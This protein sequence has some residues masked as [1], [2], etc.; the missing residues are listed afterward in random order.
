MFNYS[1]KEESSLPHMKKQKL[2]MKNY[3]FEYNNENSKRLVNNMQYNNNDNYY[4]FSKTKNHFNGFTKKNSECDTKIDSD[5]NSDILRQSNTDEDSL[6]GQDQLFCEEELDDQV[7]NCTIKEKP[8]KVIDNTKYKTEMCKNWVSKGFCN[9]GKKCKFAHGDNELEKKTVNSKYKMKLCRSFHQEGVCMYGIRCCFIHQGK[10]FDEVFSRF[11]YQMILNINNNLNEEGNLYDYQGQYIHEKLEDEIKEN[12]TVGN[13]SSENCDLTTPD[14]MKKNSLNSTL[15]KL[16][17]C[18]FSYEEGGYA[19]GLGFQEFHIQ[20]L[21]TDRG[22][23]KSQFSTKRLGVF[24]RLH[25][26]GL[27]KEQ[28]EVYPCNEN[29]SDYEEEFFNDEFN[30]VY[31][32]QYDY[33][34]NQYIQMYQQDGGMEMPYF[35]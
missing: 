34:V 32:Q 7:L 14:F 10:N 21:L 30:V 28:R 11:K 15:K 22:S 23:G 5:Q 9:Y 18:S 27:Q 8:K 31:D 25:R 6:R 1:E 19:Q 12:V 13:N 4:D 3:S 17:S 29:G 33:Q 26:H 24:D 20:K 2:G 35:F 16:G